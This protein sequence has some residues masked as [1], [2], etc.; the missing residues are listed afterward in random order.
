MSHRVR[1]SEGRQMEWRIGSHHARFESPDILWVKIRGETTL[2][3]SVHFAGLYRELGE[4]Q[5]FFIVGDLTEATTF[6][7]EGRRYMSEH[8]RPDW[9]KGNLYVG[10]RLVHRAAMRGITFVYRLTGQAVPELHFVSTEA[11]AC[12][13]VTRLRTAQGGEPVPAGSA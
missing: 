13:V 3:D 10:A 8:L 5:S 11:E 12:E 7:T 4:R 9:F 6:D 1:C 2:E